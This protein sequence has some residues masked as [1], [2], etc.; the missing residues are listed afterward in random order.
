M[1]GLHNSEAGL[2]MN[3]HAAFAAA[4]TQDNLRRTWHPQDR[5]GFSSPC[6]CHGVCGACAI[7]RGP[8]EI[9]QADSVPAQAHGPWRGKTWFQSSTSCPMPSWSWCFWYVGGTWYCE[10]SKV[11]VIGDW[12]VWYRNSKCFAMGLKWLSFNH[13]FF[14]PD[15]HACL[16]K[17]SIYK[18]YSVRWIWTHGTKPC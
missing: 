8:A 2:P 1:F 18:M 12:P 7:E 4:E 5:K 17:I 9:C 14:L 11:G 13:E 3:H 16:C 6:L 10:P 15:L